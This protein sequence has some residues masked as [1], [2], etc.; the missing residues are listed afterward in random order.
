[1]SLGKLI[2][3]GDGSERSL[4]IPMILVPTKQVWVLEKFRRVANDDIEDSADLLIV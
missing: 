3:K 4:S 2:R 1:M